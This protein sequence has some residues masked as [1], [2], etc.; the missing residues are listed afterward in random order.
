MGHVF[1]DLMKEHTSLTITY[2]ESLFQY[3]EGSTDHT[4]RAA[5]ALF[6]QIEKWVPYFGDT[7]RD[8]MTE[9]TKMTAEAGAQVFK[10]Q[11]AT[12]TVAALFRNMDRVV[13]HL[14]SFGADAADL[15]TAWTAHLNCTVAYITALKKAGSVI[16]REY[17]SSK[18]DCLRRSAAFGSVLDQQLD[19]LH[20]PISF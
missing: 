17:R 10:D 18:Q 12:T 20:T 4:E 5:D 15:R 8:I 16:G 2:F 9:H 11:D 13:S 1:E 7:W 6:A 14:E 3:P 19:Q